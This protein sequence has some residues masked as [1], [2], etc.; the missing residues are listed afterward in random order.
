M[1]FIVAFIPCDM[2]GVALAPGLLEFIAAPT[3]EPALEEYK[4]IWLIILN[5]IIWCWHYVFVFRAYREVSFAPVWI[6][7]F[8]LASC[9][10]FLLSFGHRN[11]SF[12]EKLEWLDVS[13]SSSRISPW[14]F[15][16]A[17]L[18]AC[19][20]AGETLRRVLFEVSLLVRQISSFRTR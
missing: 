13:L 5:F 6:Q 16:S 18:S 14:P 17:S 1:S 3:A 15:E 2:A 20:L 19:S 10:C 9:D 12:L 7:L 4:M 11:R 8:S